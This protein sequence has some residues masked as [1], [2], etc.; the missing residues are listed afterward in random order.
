MK[1]TSHLTSHILKRGPTFRSGLL[2]ALSVLGLGLQSS[3]AALLLEYSFNQSTGT[4]AYDTGAAPAANGTLNGGATWSNSLPSG[5]GYSLSLDG[6]NGSNVDAGVVSKIAG[7]SQLT[8]TL[9]VN[10]TAA[11]ANLDRLFSTMNSTN[12]GGMDFYIS[13]PTSGSISASNFQ[14]SFGVDGTS[15]G[16]GANLDANNQWV[17]LAVTYD[18]TL[19]S[20]NTLFYSGSVATSSSQLGTTK[21][22]NSGA[23]SGTTGSLQVGDT[24]ASPSDR[25]PS[26]LFSGLR[27][28]DTVLTS[29][30]INDVRLATVPE[31][32]AVA[33]L[34]LGIAGSLF[35]FRTRRNR[36]G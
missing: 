1:T 27:I 17:F 15:I 11:P 2:V 5:S 9:W 12:D 16:A 3:K 35:V 21:T 22:I 36:V 29:T 13:T 25:T 19:A 6:A 26:G 20:N 32:S 7:L 30:E 24:Q 14:I 28:Y 31:P 4:T 33:M 18:G 23:V 10:L 34:G 8:V